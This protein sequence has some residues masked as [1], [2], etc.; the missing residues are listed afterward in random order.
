MNLAKSGMTLGFWRIYA[1]VKIC[2]LTNIEKW[3]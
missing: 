3:E 2:L 1:N